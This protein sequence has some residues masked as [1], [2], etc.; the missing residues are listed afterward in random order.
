MTFAKRMR[1]VMADRDTIK[2]A[3]QN[4]P[5]E[6]LLSIYSKNNRKEWTDEAFAAIYLILLE[7]GVDIPEQQQAHNQTKTVSIHKMPNLFGLVCAVSADAYFGGTRGSGALSVGIG[8]LIGAP[9]GYI[10]QAVCKPR[11]VAIMV[12]SVLAIAI[13]FIA[14]IADT[15]RPVGP[16]TSSNVTR[17]SSSQGPSQSRNLEPSDDDVQ[18]ASKEGNLERLIQLHSYGLSLTNKNF[19]GASPIYWAARE[20][21]LEVLKYLVEVGADVNTVDLLIQTP[22]H[23]A[24]M[25]GNYDLV[26][27]LVEAGADVNAVNTFGNTPLHCIAAF[28]NP[29]DVM[30]AKLL[31]GKGANINMVND[32]GLTALQVSRLHDNAPVTSYLLECGAKE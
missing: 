16:G 20:N 2:N 21:H 17:P 25:Y 24:T 7:R 14:V 3:L 26:P 6:E 15:L 32:Q 4:K 5:T 8:Y 28:P 10:I 1:F 19:A 29:D 11:W 12:S 23:M 31:V 18:Q 22:L 27:F 30:V 9:I 13:A